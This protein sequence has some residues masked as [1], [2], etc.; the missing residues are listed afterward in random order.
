MIPYIRLPFEICS[1]PQPFLVRIDLQLLLISFQHDVISL[2]DQSNLRHFPPVPITHHICFDRIVSRVGRAEK[3][4]GALEETVVGGFREHL[5]AVLLP[6][7]EFKTRANPWQRWISK[8]T[9]IS[10][11]GFG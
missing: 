6:Q 4:R 5:A 7:I 1:H 8:D 11:V 9:S 10:R 3:Y 2:R